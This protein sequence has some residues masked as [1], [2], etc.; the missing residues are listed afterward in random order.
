MGADRLTLVERVAKKLPGPAPVVELDVTSAE[1]LAALP[2]RV[3]QHVDGIDGVL[4]SIGFA[5]ASA[6]GG[7]FLETP[8]DDVATAVTTSIVKPADLPVTPNLLDYEAAAA[9]PD[10]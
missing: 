8:W 1:D 4:H 3:R 6:L 9:I 7:D 2:E 10:F 5:P